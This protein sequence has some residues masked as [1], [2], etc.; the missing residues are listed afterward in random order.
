MTVT[1][2]TL[3]DRVLGCF[4]GKSIGGTLGMPF[5]GVPD[6]L[7]LTYY[8]PVPTE[9][10]ANDDLDLQLIWLLMAERHGGSLRHEHFA[11][12]WLD[13]Q[14]FPPD[15]YGVALYNLRRGVMP[16]LSG[17]HGNWFV[18]G[19]GAAIRSEIWAC[20]CPGR[21]AAAASLAWLDATV[22]HAGDGVRAE[23]FLAALQSALF[24]SPLHDAFD[25]ALSVLPP[26]GRLAPL[27]RE[28][29]DQRRRGVTLDAAREHIFAVADSPNF[30]DCV[31]NVGFI[32]LGL[33]WGEGEFEGTVLTA[34]NCGRDTDC[35]AAT[36]ASC[37]GIARG[38][39][40]FD[41]R[42]R[43]P[44]GDAIAVSGHLRHL[45]MP[46]TIQ[47]LTDRVLRLQEKFTSHQPTPQQVR[48]M[49][50]SF[51]DTQDDGHAL[52]LRAEAVHEPVLGSPRVPL[53]G[54]VGVQR[55]T[56]PSLLFDVSRWSEG[57]PQALMIGT[58]LHTLPE[59]RPA[60]LMCCADAGVTVWVDGRMVMNHHARRPMVP[61]FHRTEGGVTVPVSV[62]PGRPVDVV[63]RLYQPLRRCRMVLALGDEGGHLVLGQ[64]W[65]AR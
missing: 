25:A 48:Q 26:G 7:S 63:V 5:E 32:V 52:A 17:T 62:Q 65:G 44:V 61:A 34:V 16:P 51:A 13:H 50:V 30:T 38:P 10:A 46:A 36:S 6:R 11:Q 24:T 9:P 49:P 8:D 21:P 28:L 4:L 64:R 35:T 55:V 58:Q 39:S 37:L 60:M 59:D 19:M 43:A 31:L 2:L 27:L 57:R 47:E 42:W 20:L 41:A 23:M 53:L 45:P 56:S 14:A 29:L 33:L 3:R 15:E 40:A 1:N 22:D 54:D 12:A 18:D